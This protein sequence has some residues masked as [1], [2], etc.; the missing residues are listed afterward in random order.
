MPYINPIHQINGSASND[1]GTKH[2][3]SITAAA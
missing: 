3:L 2:P 1:N